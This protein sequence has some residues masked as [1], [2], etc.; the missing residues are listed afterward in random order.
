MHSGLFTNQNE[1]VESL[2]EALTESLDLTIAGQ[3]QYRD[4]LFGTTID[5]YI[6]DGWAFKDTELTNIIFTGECYYANMEVPMYNGYNVT[7]SNLDLYTSRDQMY[8][9]LDAGIQTFTNTQ[10]ASIY[11]FLTDN[12]EEPLL[13]TS[14][15]T[16]S[17][18]DMTDLEMSFVAFFMRLSAYLEESDNDVESNILILCFVMAAYSGM[19]LILNSVFILHKLHSD[20][21]KTAYFIKLLPW[22]VVT[23]TPLIFQHIQDDEMGDLDTIAI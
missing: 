1:L 15:Q 4:M 2:E 13:R 5:G 10:Y 6:Y 20:I 11:A 18:S 8:Q 19:I 23:E 21:S 3:A 17:A 7:C 12:M 14:L 9:G 22:H 16:T